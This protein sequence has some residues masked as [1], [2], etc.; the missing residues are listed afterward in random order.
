MLLLQILLAVLILLLLINILFTLRIGKKH[1]SNEINEIKISLGTL[2]QSLRDTEA[3][4]KGEFAINRKETADNARGLRE[5]VANQ[6]NAFTKTFSD[7]LNALTKSNE[8]KLESVR[9]T[10]DDKLNGFQL[11]IEKNSIEGRK[12]LKE[13]FDAFK[14]GVNTSLKDF[15]E[16]QRENFSDLLKNIGSQNE[17]T[18]SKL[19]SIRDTVEKK[20]TQLQE[21]NEKKLDDMRKTVDEKLDET[22]EKRL[23]ES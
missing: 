11:T 7:Q 23:G 17:T 15:G 20:I 6:L 5:E 19:D 21:G 4:L 18:A 14:I 12:E 22:L 13:S 16:R 2:S 9:K 1:S 8:N 3:N 10:I